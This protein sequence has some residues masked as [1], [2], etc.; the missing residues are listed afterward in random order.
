MR[1]DVLPTR[2]NELS[3]HDTVRGKLP[4][5]TYPPLASSES[6]RVNLKLLRVWKVSG[7]CLKRTHVRAMSEFCLKVAPVTPGER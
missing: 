3:L 1:P 7:C 4:R 6:W 2:K 5:T